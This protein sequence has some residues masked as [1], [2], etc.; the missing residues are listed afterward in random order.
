MKYLFLVFLISSNP[1][2]ANY[3]EH[4]EARDVIETLVNEHD[5]DA[6]S[7]THLT[8]PTKA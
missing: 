6:V 2:L 4:S 7:Y 1:I 8:L 3:S 5:F